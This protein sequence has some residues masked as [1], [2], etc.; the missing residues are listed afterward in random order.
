MQV[1]QRQVG[2]AQVRG[3]VS[4]HVVGGCYQVV[5]HHQGL[6]LEAVTQQKLLPA[7]EFSQRRNQPKQKLIAGFDRCTGATRHFL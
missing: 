2:G 7:R 1:F 3:F 5:Q 4:G 6:G